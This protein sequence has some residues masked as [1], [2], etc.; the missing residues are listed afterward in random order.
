MALFGEIILEIEEN[1]EM[2]GIETPGRGSIGRRVNRAQDRISQELQFPRRYIKDVNATATFELPGEARQGGL[3]W[4][5]MEAR[6]TGSA[7]PRIPLLTVAMANSMCVRWDEYDA[8]LS[9]YPGHPKFGE[10]LIIYDPANMSAPVYPL[11]FRAGDELRLEYVVKP[12][13]MDDLDGSLGAS[14]VSN[15]FE[16]QLPEYD[17]QL[18]VNYVTFEYLMANEKPQAQAYY[19]SYRGIM[20]EAFAYNRPEMA[21]QRIRVDHDVPRRW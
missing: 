13:D 18:L 2:Y 6:S 19:N 20:E 1:L 8:D 14:G 21:M 10:F 11:G 4:A 16:N 17:Q 12:R 7:N 5:E 15:P 9:S 3:L